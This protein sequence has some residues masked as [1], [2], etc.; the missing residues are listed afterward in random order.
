M[1]RNSWGP[2]WGEEGYIRIQRYGEGK[3]PCGMD[4][5]PGDGSACAGDTKAVRLCG[6]CG[7]LSDSSYPTGVEQVG[8]VPPPSPTPVPTSSPTLMVVHRL[9]L[10][11]QTAKILSF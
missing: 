10:V 8:P 3:E 11:A 4:T 5:T 7:I 1:G 6:L 9:L 2:L